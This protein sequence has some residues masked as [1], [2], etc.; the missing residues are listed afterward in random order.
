MNTASEPVRPLTETEILN[1]VVPRWARVLN[2]VYNHTFA[3]LDKFVDYLRGSSTRQFIA[4]FE[5]AEAA[6]DAQD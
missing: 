3:P 5:A 2:W 4:E 6:Q 1:N